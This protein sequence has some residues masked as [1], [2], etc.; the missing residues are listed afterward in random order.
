VP[1]LT[2]SDHTKDMIFRLPKPR[3]GCLSIYLA[4]KQQHASFGFDS[5]FGDMATQLG[6]VTL[7]TAKVPAQMEK[8]RRRERL[9]EDIKESGA[10]GKN[11]LMAR[12]LAQVGTFWALVV[13]WRRSA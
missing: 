13:A 1:S 6:R 3:R 7:N 8:Q 9:E 11:S 12:V 2:A 10:D 4:T 5:N